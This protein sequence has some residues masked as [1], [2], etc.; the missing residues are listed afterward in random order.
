MGVCT[1]SHSPKWL[2]HA[3]LK[4]THMASAAL[5]RGGS[6]AS[7]ALGRTILIVKPDMNVNLKTRIVFTSKQ[8]FEKEQAV[9]IV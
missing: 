1:H 2:I 4:R 8:A 7:L 3:M 6:A 5:G 9:I